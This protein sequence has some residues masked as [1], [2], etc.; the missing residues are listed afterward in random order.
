MQ[1]LSAAPALNFGQCLDESSCPSSSGQILAVKTFSRQVPRQHARKA[2][3]AARWNYGEF[4]KQG[5]KMHRRLARKLLASNFGDAQASM[6]E[7]VLITAGGGGG[8]DGP[9]GR[10]GGGGGDDAFGGEGDGKSKKNVEE[11]LAVLK[12]ARRS[13]DSLPSDLAEAIERGVI[14]AYLVEK[15][16]DLEK[17]PLIGLFT[18]FSGFRER[19]LADDLFL[20]KVLIECGVG[21][22]TK[23][24][25]SKASID[26][27]HFSDCSLYQSESGCCLIAWLV[28]FTKLT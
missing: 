26:Q 22:F 11:A 14:P 9:G 3:T 16:L 25:I 15:F 2:V 8:V 21:M 28:R 23:V 20:T 18:R 13:L 12:E 5:Q 17:T 7:N 4:S 1:S 6:G 19:L 27:S 10:S 24:S